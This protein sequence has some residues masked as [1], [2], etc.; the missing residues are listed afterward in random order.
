MSEIKVPS[1]TGT[2]NLTEVELEK[3]KGALR[4][5]LEYQSNE[6][7]KNYYTQCQRSASHTNLL[8]TFNAISTQM[9]TKLG[10]TVSK[11]VDESKNVPSTQI[12]VNVR[13]SSSAYTP[14]DLPA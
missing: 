7:L 10:G 8:P 3:R 5:A 6:A 9:G 12:Q 1:Y 2:L 4:W 13:F 11:W 14:I